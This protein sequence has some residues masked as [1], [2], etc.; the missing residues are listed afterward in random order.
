MNIA[1]V[2][3]NLFNLGPDTKKGTEI[4]VYDFICQLASRRQENRL[5][6]TAFTSGESKLPV[7]IQSIDAHPSISDSELM[8]D[9]KHIIF[10]L[11]LLSKAF[12]QH[13]VFDLYHINIGNG[14]IALPFV[15]F[16][17]KPVVIT[18]HY[19]FTSNYNQR[20]FAL[21]NHLP[22]VHFVS[23]SN[24]QRKSL[25]HL[26][27][28]ETIYHGIDENVFA[29][30]DV[31]GDVMMWAGRG[32]PE[33]GGDIAIQ[34]ATKTRKP[35][36]LFAIKKP[37]HTVWL[38]RN[39][40]DTLP[41]ANKH[42]TV[43]MYYDHDRSQLINHYQSSKLFLSPVGWE[44]PFGLVLIEAMACGTP[45]VAFA[46]GSIPEIV[47]DGETGF[48]VSPSSSDIRGDWIIKK[49]GCGRVMRSYREDLFVVPG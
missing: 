23:I 40:L 35:L 34:V 43:T 36:V 45:V 18:S 2:T 42:A 14:D 19:T 24:A 31:G 48:L 20:Y 11:A 28:A 33:K 39:M 41:D 1:L 6:I 21:F 9:D 25:P 32:V 10:E 44:E 27:Y 22:Q 4:F 17:K 47:S 37:T 29:F 16:V 3:S 7:P 13:D 15:P 12:S 5:D 26:N 30:N 38:K 8:R 49:D 46:R